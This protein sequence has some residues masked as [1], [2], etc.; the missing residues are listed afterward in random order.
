MAPGSKLTKVAVDKRFSKML[1]DKS[2][3]S[4]SKF[5]RYGRKTDQDNVNNEL[6]EYYYMEGEENDSEMEAE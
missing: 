4:S 3:S 6:K 1:K 5:D 2:F